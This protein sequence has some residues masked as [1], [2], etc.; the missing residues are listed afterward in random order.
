MDSKSNARSFLRDY[1][2]QQD[3]T[4]MVPVFTKRTKVKREKKKTI[5]QSSQKS[6]GMY[7]PAEQ[8]WKSVCK[9]KRDLSKN[10]NQAIA[11]CRIK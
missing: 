5:R 9:R 2:E 1:D 4:T 6:N 8:S 11:I 10:R 7:D 3:P